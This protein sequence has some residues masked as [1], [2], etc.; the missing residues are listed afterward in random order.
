MGV[1]EGTSVGYIESLHVVVETFTTTGYGE[2]ANRWSTNGMWLLMIVVQ[3]TEL[4][5]FFLTL[6]LFLVPLVGELE[7]MSTRSSPASV[8]RPD[9]GIESPIGRSTYERRTT[10]RKTVR[11]ASRVTSTSTD[12]RSHM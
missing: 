8:V 5:L 9:N 12:S 3:F 4:T 7:S 1:F 11:R 10:R 6:P 2:D